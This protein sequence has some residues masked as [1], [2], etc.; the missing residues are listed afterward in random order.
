MTNT[1]TWKRN[2]RFR[3][4]ARQRRRNQK[5]HLTRKTT[6]RADRFV[7]KRKCGILDRDTRGF[8]ARMANRSKPKC[9]IPERPPKR[10][11]VLLKSKERKRIKL[12]KEQASAKQDGW[13]LALE[14]L[15]KEL[16]SLSTEKDHVM[17]RLS[18]VKEEKEKELEGARMSMAVS[19]RAVGSRQSH[20][21]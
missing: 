12:I 7:S 6:E 21:D 13:S 14:N 15:K 11:Y 9:A 5:P 10:N 4:D 17:Q 20:V 2:T 8:A 18:T 16:A 19:R 1:T 3:N